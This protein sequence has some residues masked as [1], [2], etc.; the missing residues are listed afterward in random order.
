[1]MCP[2]D[3]ILAPSR[4]S[5][6]DEILADGDLYLHSLSIP[7]LHPAAADYLQQAIKCFRHELYLPAV[8]MLGSASEVAWTALGESLI[9]YVDTLGVATAISKAKRDDLTDRLLN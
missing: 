2:R 1:M 6:R 7:N 8:A 9:A 3:V 4:V 5:S